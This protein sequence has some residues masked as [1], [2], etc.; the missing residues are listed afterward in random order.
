MIDNS[1]GGPLIFIVTSAVISE[2]NLSGAGRNVAL[3]TQRVPKYSAAKSRIS[4]KLMYD[5]TQRENAFHFPKREKR[6]FWVAVFF[7]LKGS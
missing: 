7:L 5:P 2:M 4:D 3:G 6:L 1:G